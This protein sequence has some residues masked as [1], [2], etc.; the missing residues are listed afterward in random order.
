NLTGGAGSDVFKYT[1]I[2][3]GISDVDSLNDL[4]VG[5]GGDVID[6]QDLLVGFDS[7]KSNGA[8]FVNVIDNFD[9]AGN[10]LLKVDPDGAGQA[11][12]FTDVAVLVGVTGISAQ[13]LA[14]QGNL[15]LSNA[16]G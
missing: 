15:A 11:F 4:Q 14:D 3:D 16:T 5:P 13:D 2:G 12:G 8:D 1:E 6:V 10:S 9:G 7:G